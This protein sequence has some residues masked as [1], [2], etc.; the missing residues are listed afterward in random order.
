MNKKA[1]P[2]TIKRRDIVVNIMVRVSPPV[3]GIV[4]G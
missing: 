3:G 1:D 4:C 2:V